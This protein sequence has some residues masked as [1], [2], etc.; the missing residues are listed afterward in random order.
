[1]CKLITHNNRPC[2][3]HILVGGQRYPLV[4][5]PRFATGW[6]FFICCGVERSVSHVIAGQV[7]A[8]VTKYAARNARQNECFNTRWGLRVKRYCCW[9]VRVLDVTILLY[10]TKRN[11]ARIMKSNELQS[12]FY[13]SPVKEFYVLSIIL[14][15]HKMYYCLKQYYRNLLTVCYKIHHK[16]F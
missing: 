14:R 15:S 4:G 16:P 11:S 12:L 10:Y 2:A 7:E 9:A 1:M 6:I 13:I 8:V 3:G 5:N